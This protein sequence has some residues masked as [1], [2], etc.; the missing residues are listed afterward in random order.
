MANQITEKARRLRKQPTMAEA[1]LWQ[2]LRRQALGF[3]FRRQQPFRIKLGDSTRIFITDF[4]C[5]QKKLAIELDGK[6]H[7]AQAD[8]DQARD[9]LLSFLGVTVLRFSNNAIEQH[10]P[11]VLS[12]IREALSKL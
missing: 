12:N 11:A 4:Y 1:I 9:H 2:S 3:R 7:E 10:L 5:S 6:I 8:Y